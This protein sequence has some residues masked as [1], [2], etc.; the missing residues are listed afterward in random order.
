M[1]TI[2]TS[3]SVSMH[4]R[5][6]RSEFCIHDLGHGYSGI[7]YKNTPPRTANPAPALL[8]CPHALTINFTFTCRKS[9]QI[10]HLRQLIP[11]LSRHLW[12][13]LC[14]WPARFLVLIIM[15]SRTLVAYSSS[16]RSRTTIRRYQTISLSYLVL[17]HTTYD[18]SE[19][20]DP[21][22]IGQSIKHIVSP[23]PTAKSQRPY[24]VVCDPRALTCY[25]V[26]PAHSG[27]V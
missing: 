21:R 2:P 1:L 15:R 23:T 8:S 7:L 27:C 20:G 10:R 17:T 9:V 14:T 12:G 24:F 26:S 18:A 3:F 16:R 6:R 11:G 19:L 5:E 25:K 4:L 22:V 13:L